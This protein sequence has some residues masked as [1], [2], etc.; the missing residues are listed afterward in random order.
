MQKTIFRKD[1]LYNIHFKLI[2]YFISS[3]E[4]LD[5]FL[6]ITRSMSK[7]NKKV[8]VKTSIAT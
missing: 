8:I 7:I 2:P 1:T 5:M 4:F 3:P 6:T